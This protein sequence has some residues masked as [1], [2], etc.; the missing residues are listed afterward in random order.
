MVQWVGRRVGTGGSHIPPTTSYGESVF[1]PEVTVRIGEAQT[2][3]RQRLDEK[4]ADG[5]FETR[6]GPITPKMWS[7]VLDLGF[8]RLCPQMFL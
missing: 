2:V 8:L 3:M 4:K 7:S 6:E 1:P 5:E